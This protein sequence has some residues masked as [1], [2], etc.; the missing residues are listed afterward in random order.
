MTDFEKSWVKIHSEK[1]HQERRVSLYTDLERLSHLKAGE[2][3][4]YADLGN[5]EWC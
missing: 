2:Q 3:E 5:R 1:Y 4:V